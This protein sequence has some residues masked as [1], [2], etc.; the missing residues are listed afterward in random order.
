MSKILSKDFVYIPS[1]STDIR[2]RFAKIDPNWNRK[3]K[4]KPM[5]ANV[6]PLRKAN[7]R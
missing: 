3:P 5:P 1:G 4:A 7:V 6:R 2:K